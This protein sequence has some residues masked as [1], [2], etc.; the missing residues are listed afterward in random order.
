MCK[1]H[2]VSVVF[3]AATYD[4]KQLDHTFKTRENIAKQ[5]HV[6]NTE[7]TTKCK[8]SEM[9]QI[10]QNTMVFVTGSMVYN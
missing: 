7:N 5:K 8:K 2:R 4:K 1:F 3:P 10:T 6:A 9:P